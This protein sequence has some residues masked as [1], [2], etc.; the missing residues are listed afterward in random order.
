MPRPGEGE[1]KKSFI[2]RCIPILMDEGKVKDNKQA[3]AICYS[4]W[5]KRNEG[6]NETAYLSNYID[7]IN[8]KEE[9]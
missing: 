7:E 9:K 6:S 8:N 3:A 2:G 1:S 4:Y 5:E